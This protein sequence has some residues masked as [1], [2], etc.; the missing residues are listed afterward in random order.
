MKKSQFF[1]DVDSIEF[2]LF[3]KKGGKI[4]QWRKAPRNIK[5]AKEFL[6]FKGVKL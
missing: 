4:I 3:D 6:K 1:S 5:S 2:T